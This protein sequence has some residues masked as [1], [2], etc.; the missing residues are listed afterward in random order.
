MG[1]VTFIG[2]DI[3]QKRDPTAIA[4]AELQR[5]G[6]GGDGFKQ[7][8][9]PPVE[10]YVIRHLERLPLGT[11]Y[12]DAAKRLGE[13]VANLKRQASIAA[14]ERYLAEPYGYARRDPGNVNLT[15]YVDATG[16]GQPVVDLL[17]AAKV[18]VNP[19]YF[20]HG[21]RRTE[22][23]QEYPLKGFRVSLG[24]AWLVSRLQALLQTGRIH[25]PDTNEARVLAKE[26]QDY[27]I[28]VSE[29]ANDKYGAFKVGTHDDLVTA[30]G[31]AVQDCP[32]PR[33][34]ITYNTR[35]TL[36]GRYGY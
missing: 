29:D 20:T 25:L 23:R 4:V 17:N 9:G 2:I 5:R 1:V 7:V 19:V 18:N 6:R 14:E 15:T 12:P 22:E 36:P 26:L 28:K 31:L 30:L 24:K 27:E 13:I 16:V 35:G 34:V 3:G 21:D 32:K 10:H 8:V 11:P 33:G